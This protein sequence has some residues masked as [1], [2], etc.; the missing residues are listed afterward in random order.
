M[1]EAAAVFDQEKVERVDEIGFQRL[2]EED[3]RAL[4][5]HIL[6]HQAKPLSAITEQIIDQ[7]GL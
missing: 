4:R 7:I 1:A 3:V 6:G 5:G 2:F